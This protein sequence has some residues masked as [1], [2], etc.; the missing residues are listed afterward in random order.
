MLLEPAND[1]HLTV[2]KNI[3]N[4]PFLIY[5]EVDYAGTF[6]SVCFFGHMVSKAVNL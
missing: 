3:T 1:E 6:S 4:C 2:T 5:Y